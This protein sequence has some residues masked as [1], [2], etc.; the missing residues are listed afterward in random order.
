MGDEQIKGRGK[1]LFS[2]EECGMTKIDFFSRELLEG[3]KISL[4]CFWVFWG[5]EGGGGGGGGGEDVS[6]VCV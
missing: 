3:G 6:C 2:P 5:G 4:F 1:T